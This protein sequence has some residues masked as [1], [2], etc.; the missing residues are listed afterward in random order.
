MV[1]GEDQEIKKKKYKGNCRLSSL[2]PLGLGQ[3]IDNALFYHNWATARPDSRNRVGDTVPNSSASNPPEWRKG[4]Q[5]FPICCTF[6]LV[7]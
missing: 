7:P 5:F 1:L 4:L 3:N 2:T 6:F